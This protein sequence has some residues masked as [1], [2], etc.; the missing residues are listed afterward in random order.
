MQLESLLGDVVPAMAAH[1]VGAEDYAKKQMQE[2]AQTQE[3]IA[4]KYPEEVPSYKDIKDIGTG[5][6]YIVE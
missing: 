6:K 3:E 1:A 4:K 5:A 2:A